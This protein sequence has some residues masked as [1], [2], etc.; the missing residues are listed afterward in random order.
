MGIRFKFS[1]EGYFGGLL[2]V[3][4]SDIDFARS[5][6]G[7]FYLRKMKKEGPRKSRGFSEREYG[8]DLFQLA[9][10]LDQIRSRLRL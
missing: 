7:F 1:S 8:E 9:P 4:S 10:D 3:F 5:L 6:S 2:Y